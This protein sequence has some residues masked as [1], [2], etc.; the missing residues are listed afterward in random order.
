MQTSAAVETRRNRARVLLRTHSRQQ[1]RTIDVSECIGGT[2]QLR[3]VLHCITVLCHRRVY[4]CG[5]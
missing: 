1:Q 4:G 5:V 3:T 2:S